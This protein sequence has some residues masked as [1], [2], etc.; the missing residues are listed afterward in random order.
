MKTIFTIYDCLL[1]YYYYS[2]IKISV[3]PGDYFVGIGGRQIPHNLPD[4]EVAK[5]FHALP[6]PIKLSFT[7]C[8]VDTADTVLEWEGLR[9][10]GAPPSPAVP[11]RKTRSIKMG[12]PQFKEGD[13]VTFYRDSI[14]YHGAVQAVHGVG[15]S[16]MADVL[17]PA[18]GSLVQ[19]IPIGRL[20]YRMEKFSPKTISL[21]EAQTRQ[22]KLQQANASSNDPRSPKGVLQAPSPRGA[23]PSPKADR[24]FLRM[25][26]EG[27]AGGA[28]P[29]QPPQSTAP[30]L[31]EHFDPFGDDAFTSAPPPQPPAPPTQTAAGFDLFS[32]T[33]PQTRSA[34]DPYFDAFEVATQDAETVSNASQDQGTN[35]FDVFSPKP[36]GS[37]Q[38]QPTS[39]SMNSAKLVR[40]LSR[41]MSNQGLNSPAMRSPNNSGLNRGFSKQDSKTLFNS[42]FDQFPDVA[43]PSANK[44]VGSNSPRGASQT[45]SGS[46]KFYV[47][48]GSGQLQRGSSRNLDNN[49]TFNPFSP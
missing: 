12:P 43:P 17:L 14:A 15:N 39:P 26:S 24:A 11:L 31:V 8:P 30:R 4:G 36:P 47:K 25:P 21:L 45:S 49:T 2:S 29:P 16:A 18:S 33:P 1:I 48:T 44:V 6:M 35:P 19:G 22:L 42:A 9:A 37:F 34:A 32:P 20:D 13:L 3:Q 27:G 5:I 40:S 28:R 46:P 7:R 41:S 10:P 23:A 38:Q